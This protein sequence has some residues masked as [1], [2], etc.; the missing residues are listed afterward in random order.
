ML[1][2]NKDALTGVLAERRRQKRFHIQLTLYET[3]KIHAAD[4][5]NASFLFM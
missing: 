3:R 1:R 5:R 4:G 2:H